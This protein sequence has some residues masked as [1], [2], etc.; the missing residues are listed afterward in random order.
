M[1]KPPLPDLDEGLACELVDAKR[2]IEELAV[3]LCLDPV[4]CE[5]HPNALQQFDGL[6]QIVGEVAQILRERHSVHDVMKTIRLEAMLGRLDGAS[7]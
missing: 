3:T 5:R 2:R 7:W 1:D 4:M 6:A